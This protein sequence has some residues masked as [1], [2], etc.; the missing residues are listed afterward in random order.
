MSTYFPNRW[1][2]YLFVLPSVILVLIF[3]ILPAVQSLELSLYLASR[4]SDVR[5]F[6]GLDNFVSLFEDTQY[7]NSLLTTAAFI[8]LVVPSAL[9]ISLLLAVG[10]SQPVKGFGIYRML[11]IWTFALSPAIAG[12]IWAL[13]TDPAIG[14]IPHYLK[15]VGITFNWRT[16]GTH[17]MIFVSIAATWKILG[18]NIVFFLAG[19]KNV[20]REVIEAAA[21]DGANAWSRFT[22]IIFPLLSPV[23]FF[24]LIMNTLYAC[25]ETFGLIDITTGGGPGRS[26][27]ILIYKLYRDG[28]VS[29]NRLGSASAQSIVLLVLVVILILVQYRFAGRRTFY[30]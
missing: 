16:N 26:T 13:L 9:A 8:L 11:L 25:F 1:L 22:R 12:T 14:I 20:P 29:Q 7:I 15:Q 2:P 18:Y 23:T 5:V 24:L 6:K 17:A 10:A 28:F 4:T 3:F 27:N 19:L 21:L 30:R